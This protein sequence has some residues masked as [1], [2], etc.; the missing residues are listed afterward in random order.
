M[1][2]IIFWYWSLLSASWWNST[3]NRKITKNDLE[4]LELKW[5]KRIWTP[6]IKISF[7]N[8]DFIYNWVFLDIVKCKNSIVN[9]YGLEVSDEEF[10][11]IS[12]RESAYSMI[13]VSDKIS[14]KKPWFK[15]FTSYMN[16]KN[17]ELNNS[18]IPKKYH[19]TILDILQNK[20]EDFREKFYENLEKPDFDFVDWFYHFCD[21]K[22][23]HY[24]GRS[25]KKTNIN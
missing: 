25:T 4:Y 20:S 16:N 8:S 19:D 23:N 2:K 12:K 15:Y 11:L 10:E 21:E 17:Q 13:D 3:L 7:E 24:S 5:F 14:P 6:T 18:I 22:V 9:W 1:W